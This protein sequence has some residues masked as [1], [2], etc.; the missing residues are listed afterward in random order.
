MRFFHSLRGKLTLTYTLVTVLAL[1]ALEI[2]GGIIL[3]FFSGY[4]SG[5]PREY[6]TDIRYTLAP[7]RVYLQPGQEDTTG[8]QTWL[9]EVYDWGYASL[10]PQDLFDSPAAPIVKEDPM[11]VLSSDGTV[12][13]QAPLGDNSLV[14]RRYT[15]PDIRGSQ[16]ALRQALDGVY[17]PEQMTL[18]TPEGK[19][20][21]VLP[22][23]D[24]ADSDQVVGVFVL[25]VE[26]PPP[27]LQSRTIG[28]FIVGGLMA[29]AAVLLVGIIPFGTIFGFI[30]SRGLTRRLAALTAAADAWSEGDFRPLPLERARD[31]IGT[32]GMRMRHMAERIQ[33]L[34]QTQQELVMVEE[35][36]RLARELHDTVKQQTFATLMQVRAARNLMESDPAAAS[37][38]L[39]DAESLIK[40]AQKELNIIIA[41]LRPA[42]IAGQGLAGALR[43]YIDTW[44]QHSRIPANLHVQNE[45]ALPMGIELA[46]YRVTQEALANVARHSR[47]SAVTVQ[48]NYAPEQVH[49]T[50]ADN[51]IGF[52]A[53]TEQSSG[54]GLQSMKERLTALAGR[55]ELKSAVGTGTTVTAVVPVTATAA[56]VSAAGMPAAGMPAAPPPQKAPS[57]GAPNQSEGR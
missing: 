49:L 54:F 3:I 26:P 57:T 31:E 20:W 16:Q 13:A 44:S 35:R 12:L 5:D 2:I 41:E 33:N 23:H 7:S 37:H 17:N 50:V 11:F 39:E 1:L 56:G 52:D 53:L 10:E 30:M 22:V 15:P 27:I 47:A 32:L 8:L 48:L 24:R 51:G 28:P 55:L 4:A 46:L 19:Y 42:A 45:R 6:F 18:P 36:N 21:M 43:S 25:T 34:L 9:E 14:G 40:N 38:H 29:T